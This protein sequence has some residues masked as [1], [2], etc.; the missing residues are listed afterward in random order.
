MY[1]QE[2]TPL[3]HIFM[4]TEPAMLAAI[5]PLIDRKGRTRYECNTA[6]LYCLKRLIY[7]LN[8]NVQK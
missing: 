8:T 1:L 3:R 6:A 5:L 2:D 7:G 4:D